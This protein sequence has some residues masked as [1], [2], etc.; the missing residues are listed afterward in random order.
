LVVDLDLEIREGGVAAR[1][2]VDEPARAVDQPLLVEAH[3]ALSDRPREPIVHGEARARP[4][5][6]E[7]HGA[8]LLDDAAAVLLLPRPG[9]AQELLAADLLAGLLLADPE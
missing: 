4:V 3:E 6:R 1:A 5:E 8:Q 2:P 9:A 7:A